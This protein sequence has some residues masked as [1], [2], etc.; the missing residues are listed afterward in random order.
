MTD[1]ITKE[2]LWHEHFKPVVLQYL[3][4]VKKQME[5]EG[6]IPTIELLIEKLE[7]NE[8]NKY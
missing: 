8:N 3:K 2:K 4:D 6:S 1:S 7:D 5:D